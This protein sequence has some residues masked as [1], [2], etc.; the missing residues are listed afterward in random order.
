M[1]TVQSSYSAT[2]TAAVAGMLAN[3]REHHID[4]RV[5]E[6]AAGIGFGVA[7]SQGTADNGAVLGAAAS[8]GFVGISIK[9]TTTNPSTVDEYQQYENL[10]VLTDGDVWVTTG[11]IVTA[12]GDVTFLKTTGV[13]SSTAA[14]SDNFTITGARWMTS[15]ASGALAVVRLSGSLP[16]A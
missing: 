10:P 11:G 13:L 4:S 9:E 6:T 8:T 3:Q 7:V 5:C 1:A 12:G 15:A 14:D 16:S 2:M